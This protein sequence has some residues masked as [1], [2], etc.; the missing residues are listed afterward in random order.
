MRVRLWVSVSVA[1]PSIA[2]PRLPLKALTYFDSSVLR[3]PPRPLLTAPGHLQSNPTLPITSS[4]LVTVGARE[5]RFCRAATR[6]YPPLQR[7]KGSEVRRS[8]IFVHLFTYFAYFI[9]GSSDEPRMLGIV[10]EFAQGRCCHFQ[11][12][13]HDV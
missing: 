1:S 5:Q 4:I 6:T 9:G 3:L 10:R 2:F 12:V 8:N 7:R 11:T 13:S